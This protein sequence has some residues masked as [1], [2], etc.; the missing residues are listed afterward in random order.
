MRKREKRK[1]KR[2][3]EKGNGPKNKTRK[4][5][6][7]KNNSTTI[8]DSSSLSRNLLS[9]VFSGETLLIKHPE[10]IS[11]NCMKKTSAQLCP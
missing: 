7:S 11:V 8:V 3:S 6:E 2:I 4:I 10:L 9:L 1:M 5:K